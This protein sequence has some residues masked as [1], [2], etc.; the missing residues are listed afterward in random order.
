MARKLETSQGPL[1]RS[2][3]SPGCHNCKIEYAQFAV[4]E[5]RKVNAGWTQGGLEFDA[6][7]G[8]CTPLNQAR[9]TSTT[10]ANRNPREALIP[11]PGSHAQK[12]Q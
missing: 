4:W 5:G 3:L 9:C 8:K 6:S 11:K 2:F 10:D 1:K 12:A 7:I